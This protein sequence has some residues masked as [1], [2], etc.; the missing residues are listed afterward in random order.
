LVNGV[1]IKT[2][3][4]QSNDC[5]E[6]SILM[7][8]TAEE[9]NKRVQSNLAGYWEVPDGLDTSNFDFNWRPDLYDK[10]FI[11]QFGTQHQKTG[12]PR[13]VV[14]NSQGIKYQSH[15]HA[16]K[17]PNSLD[18]NWVVH[19]DFK[20]P[21]EFDY[22]WHPDDNDPPMRYVFG[23]QH[24]TPEEFPIISYCTADD[25]DT[26]PIKFIK[27]IQVNLLPRQDKWPVGWSVL[28]PIH[29]DTFDFSIAYPKNIDCVYVF[30]NE[31][32]PGELMPTVEFRTS[33]RA[34]KRKYI[35]L[36]RP[37][38]NLPPLDV[39]FISNGEPNAEK[40]WHH[41]LEVMRGKPNQVMHSQGVNGRVAAYQAAA[42]LSNTPWFFAVFAK[43]EIN[44][45]FDFNWQP[46]LS[47][48][49]KHYIFYATNPV[50]GLEYGHQAMIAYHRELTLNNQGQGLDFT[51]DDAHA[52]I[53]INSGIARYNID[54]WTEWRTAFRE[55]IKLCVDANRDDYEAKERLDIWLKEYSISSLA[56]EQAVEY[57]KNVNGDMD[58]L[59]LS[60]EWDWLRTKFLDGKSK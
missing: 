45:H 24:G 48:I 4:E 1:K 17:L 31:Y 11:H 33:P 40:N 49:P 34:T 27:D 32:Y 56:A 41:L 54:D 5:L 46:N 44:P 6:H 59:K 47:D 42:K 19:I 60:Y 12:G 39:I 9:L 20:Q 7:T 52:V 58:K 18:L 35:P 14:P 10:S 50:N 29:E 57:Y 30:G 53:P 55:A 15:Q 37:R 16:I 3:G 26:A 23:S 38:L 13:F 43:L 25:I 21:F 2:H 28:Q 8:I 22:S 36:P 51:M